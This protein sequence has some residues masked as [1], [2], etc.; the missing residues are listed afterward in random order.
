VR[1]TILTV[2]SRG[3]VQPYLALGGGLRAAG[4]EV[5]LATHGVWAERIRA[6]GLRWVRL[7]G[8]FHLFQETE[9]GQA[10]MAGG[11][12]PIP[13]L[14]TVYPQTVRLLREQLADSVEACAGAEALVFTHLAVAGWHLAERLGLPCCGASL[15]PVTPTRSFPSPVL[16]P[17]F[18]FGPYNRL[19]H[20]LVDAGYA[21]AW[22][23]EVNRW[24]RGSL[25]IPPVPLGFRYSRFR[26]E[27]LPLLCGFSEAVVPRP[28]DWSDRVHV[29][30]Y[31]FLDEASGY[32]PPEALAEFLEDGPK[33]VY[34]GFGS[35]LLANPE[36]TRVLVLEAL[37]R[38]GQR[39]IVAIG[40][41]APQGARLSRT[42]LALDG[43]PHDWLFPRVAAVVHHGGAGT[44]AAGLRA[45]TPTVV[46][47]LV[48]DQFFWGERVRALGVGPT[49]LAFT[50]LTADGLAAAVREAVEDD[51]I[52][53]RAAELG[54]RIRSEDG[55]ARAV[56]V[57]EKVF[58]ATPTGSWRPR[59]R[60]GDGWER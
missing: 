25:G 57:I 18:S 45:G 22:R 52:R 37:A 26:G 48:G 55:V 9:A 42:V 19:S 35:M 6:A 8:G 58:R 31:W 5:T 3:D 36:A 32:P 24:R 11:A 1:I 49:P 60:P 7:E 30:G 59:A 56:A 10:W 27:E 17:A 16:K 44:T 29:T 4:H 28:P 34:V 41:G 43:A 23:G 38:A 40:R 54:R 33:P 39:A 14:R 47:P 50:R 13:F 51:R 2:G 53:E 12:R 15:Q 46:L 21:G 20:V